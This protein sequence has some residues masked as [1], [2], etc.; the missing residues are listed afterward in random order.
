[1]SELYFNDLERIGKKL[2]K[3][4]DTS[5]RNYVTYM[6]NR[7]QQIFEYEGLPDTVPKQMLEM[8]LQAGGLVGFGLYKEKLYAFQ[9][10]YG[11]YPDAY[12]RPT[13]FI[14]ANPYLHFNKQFNV[15][16]NTMKDELP[17]IDVNDYCVIMGNDSM[18][19]GLLPLFNK[20]AA[21]LTENDITLRIAD[22]N[23]R[24]TTLISAGDDKTKNAALE[25][26]REV[27]KGNLGVLGDNKFLESLTVIPSTSASFSNYI[28]QLVEYEQYLKASWYNEIGLD[29]NYNM[30]RES[31]N[32]SET[33][34]N[35]GILLPLIDDMMWERNHAIE[36][37]N[38]LFG[39]NISVKFSS[40]WKDIR[41][42]IKLEHESMETESESESESES[43]QETEEI[44]EEEEDNNE[45]DENS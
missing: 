5:I 25:Y 14:V 45:S 7:T 26:L 23:M 42:E 38:T 36:K 4:K 29:S 37:I 40:T 18:H 22:I 6:L 24:L 43:E 10:G 19:Q 33:G 17:N 9:G 3:D 34:A 31:L 21:L 32:S 30:K 12:Y 41:E 20:Y 11:G 13:I 15:Y 8:M 28:T 39:T 2:V 44:K 1:M 16:Y 35:R 27:E